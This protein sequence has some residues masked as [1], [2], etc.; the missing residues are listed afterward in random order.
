M[1]LGLRRGTVTAVVEELDR[2]V[3]LEVDGIAC[4]AYPR[5]TGGVEVG[6]E[7]L[8]N[9]QAR[10]LELGSGGF[11][12]LYA[13]LTRGLGLQAE[14]GAHVMSLPYTPG[15]LA[16]RRGEE[17][18]DVLGLLG[19][20]PIVLCTV[21]SQVAPV[22]AA[23]AGLRVAYVQVQ[24]GALPVS[25]SDTVRQLRER[26]VL[27]VAIAVAPCLDGE[28][29]CVT[30]ASA[31]SLAVDD[32]HDAI[33]CSVGPGIVGTGTRLGTGALAL[34]DAANTA[35]ALGG[36][37]VLAIRTSEADERERHRGVSHHA[38]TVL[39][40]SLGEVAVP[41]DADGDGWEAAC[42]GLPLSHMGRGPDEDPA[43]FR[44]AYAAGV[45]ARRLLT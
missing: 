22:C 3:R 41:I 11:D 35:T 2:L 36:R 30:T 21:H 5:L 25:L 37:P 39:E 4:I 7:V 28:L 9:E 29:D 12:V 43:F 8:V 1:P 15:Q 40:L 20:V 33:V 19:R 26:G 27:S 32:G 34:A 44:A 23:L 42:S 45:A 16:L 13:N 17:D 14:E 6:D 10:L 24:G 38:E 18:R 31:F